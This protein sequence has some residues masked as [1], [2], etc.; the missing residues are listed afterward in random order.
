MSFRRV[1][2]SWIRAAALVVTIACPVLAVHAQETGGAINGSV[3][4]DQKASLPGVTVTIRNDATNA[5]LSTVTND[6]GAYVVPFVPIGKYTLTATLQGFTT[7]K[8]GDIEVRVG[9]SDPAQSR[10][11]GRGGD[12]GGHGDLAGAAARGQQRLARAGD[13]PR[14]GAGPAAAR[15]E[16][17]HA[18]AA[19]DRRA[20]HTTPP[21]RSN[22]PFD[23][24]GMDNLSIGGGRPFTNELLLDGV[25]N[26]G[27]EV[28]Q[29][30]NLSFVPSPDATAEFKVQTNLYN[31]QYGRSGG[32][33]V[34]V[35]LKSGTNQFHGSFYESYRDEA[36][37]ANTFDANRAGQAKA[38]LYWNQPGID[39]GRTRAHP[40]SLQRDRPHVLH[41]LVGADPQR[42]AVPAG[43]HRAVGARAHGRL[44]PDAHR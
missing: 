2:Q 4:D 9:Q 44:L 8:Q 24:G 6:E 28:N 39:R 23:N 29:P 35:I 7:A 11:E 19:L 22:R 37:N 27:T 21:V 20:V 31:T 18:R 41:V 36:L 43:L 25:P 34:N 3:T 10:A 13:Q 16:P 14:P 17:V 38:G 1:R 26:T 30:N 5:V 42:G 32:G 40:G 33:V 12:G 15:P